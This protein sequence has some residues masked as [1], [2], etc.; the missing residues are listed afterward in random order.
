MPGRQVSSSKPSIAELLHDD[1][2]HP[3]VRTRSVLLARVCTRA[4]S[5]FY[6]AYRAV[7]CGARA[8]G[9]APLRP[10]RAC[11]GCVGPWFWLSFGLKRFLRACV[12]CLFVL[13]KSARASALKSVG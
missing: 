1:H 4:A 6:W 5:S 3:K 10:R 12:F 11:S 8:R 7:A 9:C 13:A 2:E